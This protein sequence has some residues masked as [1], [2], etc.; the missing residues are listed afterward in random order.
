MAQRCQGVTA[1]M[2]AKGLAKLA[3]ELGELQQIVGKK[4]AFF[5]TDEHPDGKGSLK[6]RLE[7]EIADVLAATDFVRETF[8]LDHKLIEARRLSKFDRFWEWHTRVDKGCD[9]V[10]Q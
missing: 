10:D 1:V 7:E 3:E 5:H 9:G 8:D 4:L 6:V 2:T